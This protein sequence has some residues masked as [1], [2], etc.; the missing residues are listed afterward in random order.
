MSSQTSTV[1]HPEREPEPIAP[2]NTV[3]RLAEGAANVLGK[4]RMRGWI[5][6]YSAWLAIIAGA[7]LVSVSWAAS[8]PA[9]GIQR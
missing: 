5:H 3:E 4:P 6:F 7:T 2:G 8:S 9:P 1:P